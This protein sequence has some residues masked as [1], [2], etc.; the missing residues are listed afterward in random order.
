MAALASPTRGV[1]VGGIE[2]SAVNT[3]EYVTIA[4]QGNAMDFGEQWKQVYGGGGGGNSIRGVVM[5]GYSHPVNVKTIEY[6]TIA[7]TGNSAHFGE[8]TQERRYGATCSSSIRAV[9]CGGLNP[10]IENRMDYINI[11]T[12][13]NAV[14][15]GDLT[16]HMFAISHCGTSNA[17][18]GL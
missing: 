6:I 12:E 15:F 8:F 11:A 5:G 14:D 9:Y 3:I 13:G 18:G 7:T 4:T 1:L 17:H 10:A 2:G 16:D